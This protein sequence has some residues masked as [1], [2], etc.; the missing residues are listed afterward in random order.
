MHPKIL[1]VECVIET[2]DPSA[3]S[4]ASAGGAY[5][6]C[7]F[8]SGDVYPWP[9]LSGSRANRASAEKRLHAGLHVRL[10]ITLSWVKTSEVANPPMGEPGGASHRPLPRSQSKSG[11][12]YGGVPQDCCRCGDTRLVTP[13][14]LTVQDP[15]T[16][17][18]YP[19]VNTLGSAGAIMHTEEFA[20]LERSRLHNLG[21][22]K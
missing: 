20:R 4:Q 3:K 17:E 22:Q 10:T 15:A 8:C 12:Q 11:E 18:G 5:G 2:P 1:I 6:L 9:S 19:C 13:Q 21:R 16:R 14:N 7:M